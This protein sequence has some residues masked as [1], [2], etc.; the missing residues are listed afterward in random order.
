VQ[1]A[2]TLESLEAERT[3]RRHPAERRTSRWSG[4]L[5]LAIIPQ[6]AFG[7]ALL[8]PGIGRAWVTT[9]HV[10][11]GPLVVLLALLALR[12]AQQIAWR[13]RRERLLIALAWPALILVVFQL[14]IG[15]GWHLAGLARGGS[16]TML[17]VGL[18]LAATFLIAVLH[19]VAIL[20]SILI[21][22]RREHLRVTQQ[23]TQRPPDE[24]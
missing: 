14:V 16:L 20:P 3:R 7:Y 4:L 23:A 17:H 12:A 6:A 15:L 1:R 5:L 2:A 11:M 24:G 22:A 18:G 10:F 13:E 8:G 21:S 19:V 9:W